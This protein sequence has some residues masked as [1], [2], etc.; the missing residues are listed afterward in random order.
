MY[1]TR[2]CARSSEDKSATVTEVIFVLGAH[3]PLVFF[4]GSQDSRNTKHA[5]RARKWQ[6]IF[7]LLFRS[8]G[9]ELEECGTRL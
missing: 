3:P 4:A 7:K 5:S 2:L 8:C 6:R 1:R 9:S